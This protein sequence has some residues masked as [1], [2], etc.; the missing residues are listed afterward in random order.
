MRRIVGWYCEHP[1]PDD[2]THPTS[3]TARSRVQQRVGSAPS[4]C[5]VER[6][7]VEAGRWARRQLGSTTAAETASAVVARDSAD[8]VELVVA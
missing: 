5:P 3:N 4:G 7:L 2:F 8:D 1:D 6:P